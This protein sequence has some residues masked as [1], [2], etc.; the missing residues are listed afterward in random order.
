LPRQELHSNR[1]RGTLE[2][3]T[4]LGCHHKIVKLSDVGFRNRK[5][6]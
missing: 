5:S 2:D 3:P 1:W 6:I 4:Y